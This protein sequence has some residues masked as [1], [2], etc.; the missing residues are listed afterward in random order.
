WDCEAQRLAGISSFGISGTNV[1]LIVEEAPQVEFLQSDIERPLH[2]LCLSAKTE[3]AL[4]ALT[5]DY[6]AFLKSHPGLSLADICFTANTGR[7]HLKHRLAIVAESTTVLGEKF[8]VLS[9]S[10]STNKLIKG[11]AENNQN[12]IVF[13]FTGQ[14]SQYVGMARQLYETQ[15]TFR[16]TLD[17]CDKILRPYLQQPLLSVLYPESNALELLHETAYTQPALFAI[18]YALAELWKSWGIVPDAVMG[19]S[20]GEY[21][22]ACVAGVFSLEDG[23]KLI[24]ERGRLIQS[25]PQD[26]MMAV[27]FASEAQ[28]TPLLQPHTDKVSIACVNGA[29]NVV[30]SGVTETVNEILEQL[31]SQGINAQA[32]QVSHAFH[33][34]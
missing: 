29:N 20:V 16:K 12:K 3:P 6:Q 9:L 5:Q 21:V 4:V 24:A 17:R 1:H 28:I 11:V 13:L 19:H 23:L 8:R 7:S 18:E 25:L 30:I 27:V 2:L 10:D 32:L 26:G 33:S 34:P 14:G 22:A 15:P 31:K